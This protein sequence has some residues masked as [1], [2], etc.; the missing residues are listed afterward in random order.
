MNQHLQSTK[1]DDHAL[2]AGS[3][4]LN[5]CVAK[6]IDRLIIFSF[7]HLAEQKNLGREMVGIAIQ[8]LSA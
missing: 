6:K 2:K 4:F 7:G 5:I 8:E 1:K 3:S